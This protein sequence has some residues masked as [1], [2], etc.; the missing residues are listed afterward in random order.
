MS[1]RYRR[2]KHN[3]I[4]FNIFFTIILFLLIGLLCYKFY[5]DDFSSK[6]TNM[7]NIFKKFN[8]KN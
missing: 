6:S 8:E 1:R 5:V 2:R 3:N 4:I 7:P